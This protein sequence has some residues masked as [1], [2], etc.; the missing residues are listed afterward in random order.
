MKKQLKKFNE[1]ILLKAFNVENFYNIT[2]T[3]YNISF[4]GKFNRETVVELEKLG[5]KLETTEQGYLCFESNNIS[6]TLT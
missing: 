1:L 2:I 6:I 4:Q 3:E 5:Y